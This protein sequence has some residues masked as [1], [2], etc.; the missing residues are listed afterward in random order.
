MG[1]LDGQ[2]VAIIELRA[3][4][5]SLGIVGN[6][7]LSTQDVDSI[8]QHLPHTLHSLSLKSI[9]MVPSQVCLLQCIAQK[10]E[11]LSTGRRLSDIDNLLN[12][13]QQ[14]LFSSL[15]YLDISDLRNFGKYHFTTTPILRS[16]RYN[17]A[18]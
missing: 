12:P 6:P 14:W 13:N 5:R 7:L 4:G 15:Q 3:P 8:L 17:R 16:T 18:G 9:N 11:H 1:C 2:S 10:L